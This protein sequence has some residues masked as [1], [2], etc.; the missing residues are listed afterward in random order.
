MQLG[1]SV[2]IQRSLLNSYR[3]VKNGVHG[4]RASGR[5]LALSENEPTPI[6][7]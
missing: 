7:A 2:Y 3:N 1:P 5:S 4:L 6:G